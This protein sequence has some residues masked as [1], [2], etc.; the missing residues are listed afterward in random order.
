M[1]RRRAL[2]LVIAIAISLIAFTHVSQ[3]TPVAA[4]ACTAYQEAPQLAADV[5][6][7][8]LPAVKDRL[9]KNPVV[10]TPAEKIGTYGGT[11][12][13]LYA[14]VRLAEFRLYGYENLVRWSPDGSKV[15]PNIAE[16]WDIN[17]GGKEYVFHLRDGLKWSDGKPF[18]SDD[19]L[20]W[21]NDVET[22]KEINPGGP[23][24][25]FVVNGQPATVKAIDPL[26]VSFSWDNPHGL[27]LQNL[28]AS[29]G[30]RVTQFPKHYL[31]QFS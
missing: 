31:A 29:Y 18:T 7:G 21:W 22:D 19:I 14:G 24:S 4:A 12:L 16:S 6:A 25:Y 1:K 13:N 30:V 3:P 26:T 10:D 17:N 15:V 23:H 27:L 9:P 2:S 5:A 28:S 8:K 11:M 20:F